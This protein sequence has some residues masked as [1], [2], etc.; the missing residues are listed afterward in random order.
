MRGASSS[1]IASATGLPFRISAMFDSSHLQGDPIYP[2][3]ASVP[4]MRGHDGAAHTSAR[5]ARTRPAARRT[6]PR[7]CGEV[8]VLERLGVDE[9]VHARRLQC[10]TAQQRTA[11]HVG[12]EHLGALLPHLLEQLDGLGDLAHH[13][14][15]SGAGV[16]GGLLEHLGAPGVLLGNAVGLGERI[17]RL[18]VLLHQ[19]DEAKAH[20]VGSA[21]MRCTSSS[22][23]AYFFLPVVKLPTIEQSAT[24]RAPT[25][26]AAPPPPGTDSL[27]P[28]SAKL[29]AA[30]VHQSLSHEF[31]LPRTTESCTPVHPRAPDGSL[32]RTPHRRAVRGVQK[33]RTLPPERSRDSE[34]DD[35]AAGNGALPVD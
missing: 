21:S 35:V 14:E 28:A 15:R 27:P 10:R 22:Y 3:H 20:V 32:R 29:R 25:S 7:R 30:L 6:R 11:A 17:E 24:P 12:D 5:A 19:L 31:L 2:G 18:G 4:L 34:R 16:L 9:H 8:A 1:F 13:L 23:S 33:V 26:A